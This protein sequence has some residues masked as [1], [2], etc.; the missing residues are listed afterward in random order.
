MSATRK[1][2][3]REMLAGGSIALLSG[4]GVA[5]IRGGGITS[6]D[7]GVSLSTRRVSITP[8]GSDQF[9]TKIEA[10]F[11]GLR[12]EPRFQ[13]I[14][15]GAY[16]VTNSSALSIKALGLSWSTRMD[17]SVDEMTSHLYHRPG[18]RVAGKRMRMTAQ[19]DLLKPGATLLVTPTFTW[20]PA[21][22]RKHL[23][24]PLIARDK[25]KKVN[26]DKGLAK[27]LAEGGTVELKID[28]AIHSDWRKIGPDTMNLG[29]NIAVRRTA[30]RDESVEILSLIEAK[31]STSDVFG[32]LL[33]HRSLEGVAAKSVSQTD[34]FE[35]LY[36]QR[37]VAHAKRL[38]RHFNNRS[39][40]A[41]IGELVAIKSQP[42][43]VIR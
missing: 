3:R 39:P 32:R 13:A 40:K 17:S 27:K 42:E 18:R 20:S 41:F 28:V 2:S 22:F 1:I 25:L 35:H 31:G 21:S 10:L 19:A 14:E 24:K 16:L 5:A 6:N 36:W 33:Q 37:R 8:S 43:T 23:K 9:D 29:K 11:P 12:F 26:P 4:A 38:L 7:S 30:E 34:F 15:R